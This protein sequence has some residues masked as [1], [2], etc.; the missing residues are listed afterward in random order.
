MPANDAQAEVKAS[1]K[2]V[3]FLL[4]HPGTGKTYAATAVGWQALTH[5]QIR[6]VVVVRSPIGLSKSLGFLPGDLDSKL[7]PW[8]RPYIDNLTEILDKDEGAAKKAFSSYFTAQSLEHIQGRSIS[9]S[10]IIVDEAQDLSPQE[11]KCLITRLGQSSRIIFAG[12][13]GQINNPGRW[14]DELLERF[15][16]CHVKANVASWHY[17]P[18]EYSKVRNPVMPQI[19]E[20]NKQFEEYLCQL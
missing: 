7:E 19:L 4:G 18:A 12:D 16:M 17:F 8:M 5:E 1:R 11:L 20:A 13:P 15:A 2:P 9:D 6:R 14:P 10:L 3:M